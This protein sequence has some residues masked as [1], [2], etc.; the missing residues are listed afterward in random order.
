MRLLIVSLSF[1]LSALF[2]CGGE[3]RFNVVTNGLLADSVR[4]ISGRMEARGAYWSFGKVSPAMPEGFEAVS[5]YAPA[6]NFA[7]VGGT[8]WPVLRIYPFYAYGNP[9]YFL[10]IPRL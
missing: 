6:W 2:A 4:C 7:Y 10:R 8:R 5:T 3:V 1:V 9:K